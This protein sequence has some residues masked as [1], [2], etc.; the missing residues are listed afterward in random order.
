MAFERLAPFPK[1]EKR[2][3]ETKYCFGSCQKEVP[4]ENFNKSVG[5]RFCKSCLN[6]NRKKKRDEYKKE[7]SQFF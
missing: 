2:V 7:L 5:G 1:Y 3:T 4:I 6:E